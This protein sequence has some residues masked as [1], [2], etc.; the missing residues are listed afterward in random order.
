MLLN[1][2]D[3]DSLQHEKVSPINSEALIT[4]EGLFVYERNL[5]SKVRCLMDMRRYPHDIQT[6]DLKFQSHSFAVH[7]LIF[8]NPAVYIQA[9][10]LESSSFEIFDY[11]AFVRTILYNRKNFSQCV[12]QV[13]LKRRLEYF[14]YQVK[15]TSAHVPS[16][17]GDTLEISIFPNECCTNQKTLIPPCF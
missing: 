6:C 4:S 9:N 17:N 1:E 14:L 5:V 16:K 2:K 8:T 13:Q 11:H 15:K 3:T 7:T 12:V 10:A